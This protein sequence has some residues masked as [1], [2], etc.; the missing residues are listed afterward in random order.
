M[1][2]LLLLALLL[3]LSLKAATLEGLRWFDHPAYLRV[4]F[5]ISQAVEYRVSDRRGSGYLDLILEGSSGARMRPR[6]EVESDLLAFAEEKHRTSTS[7]I[8]RLHLGEVKEIK[9]FALGENPFKIVIDLYKPGTAARPAVQATGKPAK[10]GKEEKTL[11]VVEAKKPVPEPKAAVRTP[12]KNSNQAVE[13]WADVQGN[14]RRHMQVASLLLE[15]EDWNGALDHLAQAGARA[16]AS[17]GGGLLAGIAWY[18]LGDFYRAR[19]NLENAGMDERF[20]ERAEE[21][22][23]AIQPAPDGSLVGGEMLEGDLEYYLGILRRGRNLDYPDLVAS[24]EGEQAQGSGFIGGLLLGTSLAALGAL[25]GFILYRRKEEERR[26]ARILREAE[27][28]PPQEPKAVAQAPFDDGAA[29][30]PNRQAEPDPQP[31][32]MNGSRAEEPEP[33]AVEPKDDPAAV[34]AEEVRP[35]EEDLYAKVQEELERQM[36]QRAEPNEEKPAPQPAPASED[37]EE[38]LSAE[39]YKM[40]DSNSPIVEIAETLGMGEDEVKLILDLR[41]QLPEA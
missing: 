18:R 27:A 23:A 2:T 8:W 10:P 28:L 3:P 6:I 12:S 40:A 17:P 32:A 4:V 19:Q 26:R 11:P 36:E 21:L 31:D 9:H 33:E 34:E 24:A 1:R 22:L 20:R 25:L 7:L 16:E 29:S 14:A 37:E 38:D 39:V 41:P 30:L 5:D 35:P 15:L 13:A